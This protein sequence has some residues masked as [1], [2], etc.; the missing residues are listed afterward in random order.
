MACRASPKA[1]QIDN[2]IKA[3]T[4][5]LCR[6]LPLASVSTLALATALYA[7]DTT[8]TGEGAA[9][10]VVLNPITLV[11]DGQENVEA[12]GGVSVTQEDIEAMQPAD[13]SEL[14]QRD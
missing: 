11:A 6:I 1:R 13:V 14:F 12:T 3:L 2:Q 8:Q 9:D 4:M 7:Q 10:V 5:R